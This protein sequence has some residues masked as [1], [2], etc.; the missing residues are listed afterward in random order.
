MF[1]QNFTRW[2]LINAVIFVI[3]FQ[4]VPVF[5]FQYHVDKP[6]NLKNVKLEGALFRAFSRN[7]ELNEYQLDSTFQRFNIYSLI[8]VIYFTLESSGVKILTRMKIFNI[9]RKQKEL[10][11]DEQLEFVQNFL[12]NSGAYS[13]QQKQEFKLKFPKLKFEIKRVFVFNILEI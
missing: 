5:N 13:E 8:Y 4:R 12:Q 6:F 7:M 9:M 2:F 11:I 3:Q 10:Y 1:F